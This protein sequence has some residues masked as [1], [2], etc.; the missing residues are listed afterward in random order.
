MHAEDVARA[1]SNGR[2]V[3]ILQLCP[4][5]KLSFARRCVQGH[6]LERHQRVNEENCVRARRHQGSPV[7]LGLTIIEAWL[8][9]INCALT[10]TGFRVHG[11]EH[12]PPHELLI[13]TS[14]GLPRQFHIGIGEHKAFTSHDIETRILHSCYSPPSVMLHTEL[15]HIAPAPSVRFCRRHV[16]NNDC[17][18][19]WRFRTSSCT[20]TGN[21]RRNTIISNTTGKH[22]P[23]VLTRWDTPNLLDAV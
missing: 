4:R 15:R 19:V 12:L 14:T 1:T 9:H 5:G 6:D 20:Y 3:W 7:L 17:R 18:G 10:H 16:T 21:P 11:D 2:K 13:V 22:H 23:I 8:H